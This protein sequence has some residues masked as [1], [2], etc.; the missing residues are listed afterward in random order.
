MDYGKIQKELEVYDKNRVDAFC[1]YLNYLKTDKTKD[2]KFRNPW[3]Q[4]TKEKEVVYFFKQVASTGLWLDG[5]IVTL[6]YKGKLMV[7]FSYQAYKNL[8]LLKYPETIFDM[9]VVKK[10]DEFCFKKDSGKVLYSH[11][12]TSAFDEK[13]IIG[14]YCIIKNKNGEFIETMS[15]EEI[16]KC[17]KVAKTDFI[18]KAWFS[19]MCL[20]TI[21]KR[22]C[23]RHF[24]DIVVNAEKL[25]NENYDLEKTEDKKDALLEAFKS[26]A[27]NEI[28]SEELVM[29]FSEMQTIDEKRKFYAQIL[30][31]IKEAA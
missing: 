22:A 9:Q 12:M 24:K 21:I 8:V 16:D 2:G 30:K 7:S 31:R 15:R 1:V 6:Q 5:D 13:P 23:K 10:D 26:L 11:K 18:W 29:Q 17:R 14:A 4:Q 25:D 3:M 20:K 19:E 28:D 27:E